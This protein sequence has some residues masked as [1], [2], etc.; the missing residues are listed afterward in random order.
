MKNFSDEAILQIALNEGLRGASSANS[1]LSIL[2]GAAD[3]PT[4]HGDSAKCFR[5]QRRK[6]SR[7]QL[8]KALKRSWSWLENL[9]SMP[10]ERFFSL[11]TNCRPLGD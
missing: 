5:K 7:Q 8:S 9:L 11:Q 10:S 6:A 1:E 2:R 3:D 4:Q